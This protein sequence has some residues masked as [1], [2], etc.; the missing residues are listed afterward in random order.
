GGGVVLEFSDEIIPDYLPQPQ[1]S[2]FQIW[3]A[4]GTVVERSRSLAGADLP[5]PPTAAGDDAF[6]DLELPDGRPGRAAVLEYAVTEGHPNYREDRGGE[7][8]H[9]RGAGTVAAAAI[10]TAVAVVAI[11]RAPLDASLAN[12]RLSVA[13]IALGL[14][15]ASSIAVTLLVGLG[16]RP[17]EQLGEEVGRLAPGAPPGSLTADGLPRELAPIAHR[18][19]E[20]LGRVREALERERRVAANMAHELRTPVSELMSL[21]EV[22]LRWSD[23]ETGLRRTVATAR[24]IARRMATLTEIVLRLARPRGE[25]LPLQR[26]RFDLGALVRELAAAGPDAAAPIELDVAADVAVTSDPVAVRMILANLIDNAREHG[27]GGPI[28]CAVRATPTGGAV[29]RLE[30]PAS[31]LDPTDVQ[32]FGERFWRADESRT[33]GDRPHFGLGLALAHELCDGIGARLSHRLADGRLEATL[34]LPDGDV[35]PGRRIV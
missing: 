27:S 9:Q 35:P 8:R 28:R 20:L 12:L 6:C 2:Y 11:G 19:D 33:A 5:R 1:P 32:R 3:L 25:A 31:H 29:V 34:E 24:D 17:L 22:T 26:E 30:N 23:G 13:L 16:L 15:L 14:S 10:P 18:I 4:D 7:I 21:T